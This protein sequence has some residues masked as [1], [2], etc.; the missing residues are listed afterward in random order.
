MASKHRLIF[1]G[2]LLVGLLLFYFGVNT[3]MEQKAK[4]NVPPPPIVIKQPEKE[5]KEQVKE[6]KKPQ[7]V[8]QI[9]SK[10]VKQELEKTTKQES[11][12]PKTETQKVAQETQPKP[13]VEKQEKKVTKKEE[14]RAVAKKETRKVTKT[15]TKQT[16]KRLK[17]YVFQVGAFKNKANAL[18]MVRI[19]KRKG[20]SAKLVKKGELYKV[21]VYTKA[22]SFTYAYK[23]V[24][25]HFKEAFF[26]RK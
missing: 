24:K 1:L 22:P 17:T 20:F 16:S 19:A 4:E 8:A 21:Y 18:K 25:K 15:P 9:S 13:S 10:E 6:E 26:V 23:K 7:D 12:K 3:W 14:K 2:T 11:S 5:T